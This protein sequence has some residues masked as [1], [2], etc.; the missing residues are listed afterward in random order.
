MLVTIRSFWETY[1]LDKE[2][3]KA[4]IEGIH[5]LNREHRKDVRE[6]PAIWF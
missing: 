4:L 1:D 5:E 3:A 2:Y 6:W